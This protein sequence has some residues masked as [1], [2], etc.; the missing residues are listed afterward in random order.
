MCFMMVLTFMMF[1]APLQ[2]LNVYRFYD[3][4]ISYSKHFG[5]LFFVC[6]IIAVSRS[7]VNPIIYAWTNIRFRHGLKYFICCYC[8]DVNKEHLKQS[9]ATNR[10][11]TSEYAK[12]SF[13]FKSKHVDENSKRPSKTFI[14]LE[15][16]MCTRHG[17]SS[18][19]IT[20]KGNITTY[21]F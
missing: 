11:Q 19:N 3:E 10:N 5:D 14:E 17:S 18:K 21:T 2:F 7:F 16:P 6:H 20:V 13:H 9:A 15:S 1:W 8:F 12:P 4:N